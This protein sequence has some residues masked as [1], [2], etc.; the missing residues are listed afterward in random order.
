MLKL[1]H[2]Q[3]TTPQEIEAYGDDLKKAMLRHACRA[4]AH[5]H[6]QSY[7]YRP[8]DVAAEA[9]L[10]AQNTALPWRIGTEIR[11]PLNNPY[12]GPAK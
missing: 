1:S 12:R 3:A 2:Q 8:A 11:L 6:A 9:P 4:F 10:P 7:R 5:K